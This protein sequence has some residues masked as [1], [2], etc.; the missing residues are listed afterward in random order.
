MFWAARLQLGPHRDAKIVMCVILCRHKA[1]TKILWIYLFSTLQLL[2]E[3][4]MSVLVTTIYGR[5]RGTTTSLF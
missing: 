4:V 2:H 5:W 3:A 1:L